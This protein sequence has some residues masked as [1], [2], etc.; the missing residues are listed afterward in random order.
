MMYVRALKASMSQTPTLVIGN[1]MF[2]SLFYLVFHST[3]VWSD[4]PVG[5]QVGLES[6][7]TASA[8]ASASSGASAASST[9]SS[10][11]H[12][13]QFLAAHRW[14]V[15]EAERALVSKASAVGPDYPR[16]HRCAARV[17]GGKGRIPQCDCESQVEKCAFPSLNS[18]SRGGLREREALIGHLSKLK[19]QYRSHYAAK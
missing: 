2:L 8:S 11:E 6:A 15:A 3:K 12:S 17:G 1:T 7:A 14:L 5:E 19:G 4:L 16:V 9:A 13:M 10:T 18:R